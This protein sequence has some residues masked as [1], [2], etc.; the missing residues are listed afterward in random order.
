MH[1]DVCLHHGLSFQ[2]SLLRAE[3]QDCEYFTGAHPLEN[4]LVRCRSA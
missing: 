4:V 2:V 3:L 1:V